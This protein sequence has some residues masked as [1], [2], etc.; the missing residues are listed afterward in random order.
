MF[1]FMVYS[2]VFYILYVSLQC[3]EGGMVDMLHYSCDS[4]VQVQLVAERSSGSY[5]YVLCSNM[6]ATPLLKCAC[7]C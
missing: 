5:K 7:I 6:S 3:L 4:W 2:V 1:M